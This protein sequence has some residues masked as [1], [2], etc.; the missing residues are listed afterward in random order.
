MKAPDVEPVRVPLHALTAREDARPPSR[1]KSFLARIHGGRASS[2]AGLADRF[3]SRRADLVEEMD[4]PDA[5]EELLHRTLAQFGAVNRI[6]ARYRTLLNR[7]VL[8]DM[9]ADGARACRLVDLGAGGCDIDRWLVDRCRRQ[10]L[11]LQITAVERDARV[12]RFARAAN[13]GYP[14]IELVEADVMDGRQLAGADYVFANHL[15]HHL[16]SERCVELIRLIDRAGPR[17]YVLGD[18]LRSRAAYRSYAFVAPLLF[19]NSFVVA[20]GLASIRRSFTVSE[21][22]EL[23]AAASPRYPVTVHSMLPGRLVIAGRK[24]ELTG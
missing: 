20:D 8:N 7:Y 2:R 11:K 9:A 19:R 18:I 24:S 1:R 5:S 21:A 22:N 15:L 16:S 6:F 10:G 17:A 12:L 23:V 3:L 13:A 4:R 14:E